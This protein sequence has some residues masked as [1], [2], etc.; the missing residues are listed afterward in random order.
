[1]IALLILVAIAIIAIGGALGFTPSQAIFE[2]LLVML[3]NDTTTFLKTAG[4][5]NLVLLIKAPFTPGQDL[6]IG[7]LTEADFDDYLPRDVVDGAQPQSLDPATGDSLMTLA[8]G[9]VPYL[10]ETGSSFSGTQTIYGY[11]ITDSTKAVLLGS[12]LLPNGPVLLTA[13]NQSIQILAPVLRQ[14]NG[15][16][17]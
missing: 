4:G 15:S 1:M 2:R 10:W 8:A 3:G 13:P 7:D 17:S 11:A 6:V 12:E 14:L 9:A 16:L 5:L